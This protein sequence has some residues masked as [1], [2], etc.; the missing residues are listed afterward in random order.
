MAT[1]GMA[2][3][4]PLDDDDLLSQILLRLPP[5]PAGLLRASLVCA[6]WRRLLRDPAVLRL[7]RAF[8]RTPPVL[9]LYRATLRPGT[10]LPVGDAPDRVAAPRLELRTDD[11][12]FL[13]CRHGRVLLRSAPGW[14]QLLVWDPLTG[15]RRCVRLGRLGSHV[16]ACSAAV[17]GDPAG[18]GRR[19]GSF[20]LAFVFTG[21]GRASACLYSSE[22]G[23]WGKLI[24]AE[25]ICDDISGKPS[26][27]AGD[28]LYWVLDDGDILELHLGKERLAI[29]EP[30]PDARSLYRRNSLLMDAGGTLGFAGVNDYSLHLWAWEADLDGT[31]KWVRRKIID[32]SE[33]AP[34]P[35]VILLMPH[36]KL[37]CV[38]ES[39]SFA[40]IRTAFG[41][42]MVSLN[43]SSPFKKV[44][45]AELFELFR[46]Y[47]S[48]YV[49]GGSGCAVDADDGAGQQEM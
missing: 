44:S 42:Y 16:D 20:R 35:E 27:L 23:A 21:G 11:W 10:F 41:M 43:A 4:S 1:G 5:H 33:F 48:F 14:L 34:S 8:H 9:G 6:R 38:D 13:A 39:G 31:A 19:R 49:E 12:V 45:D 24:T 32:L 29:V 26:A 2:P 18:P 37:R 17:F 40:F 3:P 15:H 22:A 30:P 46:P 7:S 25:A 36:V 47:S 28:A